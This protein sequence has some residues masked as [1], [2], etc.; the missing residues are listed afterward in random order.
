MK[1]SA[2]N[3]GWRPEEDQR[4][5]QLLKEYGY[6]GLEIAPT[7]VFPGG[8]MTICPARPCLPG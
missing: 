4:V 5:W 6:Q 7:R 1:C 8:P 3:I 2:S